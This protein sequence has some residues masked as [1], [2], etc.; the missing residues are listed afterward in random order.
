MRLRCSSQPLCLRDVRNN[1]L[2][3]LERRGE[4]YKAEILEKTEG[5]DALD[6]RITSLLEN[7]VRSSLNAGMLIALGYALILPLFF[8]YNMRITVHRAITM[9]LVCTP[10]TL[11]CA[12]PSIARVSMI[13]AAS[14]GTVFE[15]AADI[16]LLAGTKTVLMEKSC[17]SEREEQHILDYMSPGLDD[18]TFFMLI[19]HLAAL[20]EQRF[21]QD[22]LEENDCDI[23][24]D[25]ISGFQEAPGGMEGSIAGTAVIFGTRSYLAG[26]KISAPED[27][28]DK[29]VCYHLYAGGR[30]GG[31]LV[32]SENTQDDIADILHDLRF[33]GVNRCVLICEESQEEIAK[34]S[35]KSEFDDVFAGIS[36]ENRLNTVNEVYRAD[37]KK[38]IYFAPDEE[39]ARSEADIE[40]RIGKALGDADALTQREEYSNV[41]LLL[42]LSRRMREIAVE[43]AVIAFGIK[44]VIIFFSLIGYCNL[45]MAIIADTAAA[46]LTIL[47]ANRVTSKSL[48]RSFL[49]K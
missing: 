42:A 29:G 38:K 49:D 3:M 48:V 10:Y 40:I 22:I 17:F 5:R 13:F 44:A 45:W 34:Y 11:V 24:D 39:P 19:S 15:R 2:K 18:N 7:S 33:N 46:I 41:P 1:A 16:E 27:P 31:Y 32:L 28:D 47:N 37:T 30:Y 12:V 25:L 36:S 26:R 43:N 4:E 20:S 8:H 21:A 9:L 14:K 23:R 6:L 35:I